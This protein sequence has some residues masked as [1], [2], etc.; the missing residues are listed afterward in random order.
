MYRREG[1]YYI[2]C[3]AGGVT[4]GYQLALR[5]DSP[6]G[7]YER[8]IVLAQGNTSVNGPH[9]G[10]WVDDGRGG[11]YFV[12]FQDRGVYGRITHLQPVKWVDGWPV[13]GEDGAPVPEGEV[14]FADSALP[15][16]PRM[17]DEFQGKMS[18]QWQWQA[19]PNGAWFRPT[20]AGL[21]LY[22]APADSLFHA[23]Q[24]L[25]QLM[26]AENFDMDV[27]LALHGQPG[28]RAGLGMMG[29]RYG[30]CALE[31]GRLVAV[32]GQA[33]G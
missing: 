19:N 20:A 21:R 22:A 14:P 8:K 6:Y 23:G 1:K 31:E 2:L 11:D 24:F 4:G 15:S 3:P 18:L 16:H 26:Q 10:G 13:M 9:Q 5:A 33:K 32:S 30:Y 29:Y 27:R 17:S 7:P 12:H 25:S 28:D